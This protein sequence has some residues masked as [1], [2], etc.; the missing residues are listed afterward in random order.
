MTL[1]LV[2]PVP[3]WALRAVHAALAAG[4]ARGGV[5]GRPVRGRTRCS[6]SGSPRWSSPGS[7]LPGLGLAA[8][9]VLVAGTRLLVG[10]PP[11]LGVVM[12]SSCWCT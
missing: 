3:A 4:D 9:V 7:I 5:R 2:R 10:D 12:A 6:S 1:D 8:L 11:A